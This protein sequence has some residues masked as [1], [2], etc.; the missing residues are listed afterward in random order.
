MPRRPAALLRSVAPFAL[1]ACAACGPGHDP[2][3]PAGFDPRGG[4]ATFNF[5]WRI[6]GQDPT[7]AADPCRTADVRFIRMT[8]VDSADTSRELEAF[9]FDCH[10]GSYRSPQPELRAG[11][12]RLYW[13]A[14]SSTGARRS[15]ASGTYVD[16]V[17]QPTL[18]SLT[19]VRGVH[20]DFDASNRPDTTFSGAP[21]NFSTGQGPLEVGLRFAAT[22]GAGTGTDCTTAG[23]ATVSWTL[24]LSNH[25]PIERHTTREA[26]ST[27]FG[28]LVWD[29]L[30]F[31]RYTLEVQGFDEAGQERWR[32]QCPDVLV[33]EAAPA[34][35][36]HTC[37]LDRLGG[38]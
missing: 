21:T 17:L 6:N 38:P 13:E 25:V 26:C 3:P 28:Q 27:G 32:G 11:A 19:V 37:L 23:V 10:L 24:R 14:I 2:D 1:L 15:L 29:A 34:V 9:R 31:D 7:D 5:S 30:H 4:D 33:H 20:V 22:P 36:R 16:G 35:A 8:V 12:Y 18:E